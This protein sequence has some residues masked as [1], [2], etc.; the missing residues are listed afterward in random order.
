MAI[1]VVPVE[2]PE[3]VRAELEEFRRDNRQLNARLAALEAEF[4]NQWVAMKDGRLFHA[5][6]LDALFAEMR[7]AGVDPATAPRHYF[8]TD[9]PAMIL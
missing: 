9:L 2:D 5:A 4:P 1:T 6:E 3:G 8:A 7:L